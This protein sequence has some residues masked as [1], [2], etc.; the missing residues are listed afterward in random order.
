MP[1]EP[2]AMV[3]IAVLRGEAAEA[4]CLAAK[5]KD[6]ETVT[7]LLSYAAALEVDATRCDQTLSDREN[8]LAN[9]NS[10]FTRTNQHLASARH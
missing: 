7:D 9:D 10:R 1:R 3:D 5:F 8:A 2:I 6:R 4:R